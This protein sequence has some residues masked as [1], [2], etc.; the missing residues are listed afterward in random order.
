M[1]KKCSK[2]KIVFVQRKD[3]RVDWKVILAG[4]TTLFFRQSTVKLV[5][6]AFFVCF[7]GLC[8]RARAVGCNVSKPD[9]VYIFAHE[10]LGKWSLETVLLSVGGGNLWDTRRKLSEL[11]QNQW[12]TQLTFER[13]GWRWSLRCGPKTESFSI[14]ET[15]VT[16]KQLFTCHKLG[17]C[18]HLVDAHE[19]IGSCNLERKNSHLSDTISGNMV[20][21]TSPNLDDYW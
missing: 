10:S 6:K 1:K 13:P 3:R 14:A 9:L 7:H 4:K 21:M 15:E 20:Y 8:T 12:Q 19:Y 11:G 18:N 5:Q 2:L 17:I 16:L